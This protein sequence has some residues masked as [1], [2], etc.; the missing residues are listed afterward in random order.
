MWGD[1]HL[2]VNFVVTLCTLQVSA[3]SDLCARQEPGE[4]LI[5][6]I[7][8]RLAPYSVFAIN[9]YFFH[10]PGDWLAVCWV[11]GPC[12]GDAL[13]QERTVLCGRTLL[14]V[15]LQEETGEGAS[16]E[17]KESQGGPSSLSFTCSLI[18]V[19]LSR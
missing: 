4:R 7:S 6:A 17:V 8:T 3:L 14:D 9:T 11:S 19:R 16:S 5:A 15:R 2:G 10:H 1:P 12:L 13:L 18:H